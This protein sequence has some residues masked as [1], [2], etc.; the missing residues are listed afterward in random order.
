MPLNLEKALNKSFVV[1]VII[2]IVIIIIII[3]IIIITL[4]IL[5]LDY[6]MHAKQLGIRRALF[7]SLVYS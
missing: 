5:K 1:V 7:L 4:G 3:I 6:N 2:I